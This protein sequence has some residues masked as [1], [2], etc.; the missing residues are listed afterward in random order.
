MCEVSLCL[1]SLRVGVLVAV[2]ENVDSSGMTMDDQTKKRPGRRRANGKKRLFWRGLLW[3]RHLFLYGL[4]CLAFQV[5]RRLS[6]KSLLSLAN[7]LGALVYRLNRRGRRVARA[8]IDVV[9][10]DRI[11]T[12]RR[13]ILVRGSFRNAVRAM[14]DLPWFAFRRRQRMADYCRLTGGAFDE[15]GKGP[16]IVVTVHIGNWEI[17]GQMLADVCGGAVSVAMPIKNP[18][19]DVTI[20]KLRETGGQRISTS[21]GAVRELVRG[22]RKGVSVGLVLDQWTEPSKGGVVVD[23]LGLPTCMSNAAGVLASRLGVPIYVMAC[24]PST[25][26]GYV[27][28]L[29]E[30]IP[31]EA[32][33]SPEALTQ[34]TADSLGRLVRRFPSQWLWFYKRWKR[35]IPGYD[36]DQFPFYA[37]AMGQRES[38]ALEQ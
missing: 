5:F 13:E 23:F 7:G 8:N 24:I 1:A 22:L 35:S 25:A 36:P 16:C 3:P 4:A 34:L 20:S 9:Y 12:H 11:S 29:F 6:R 33:I 10:G 38:K 15:L 28:S 30:K 32:G 18:L 27:G 26:G 21:K 17:G 2:T 19:L 31:T 14:V 37:T